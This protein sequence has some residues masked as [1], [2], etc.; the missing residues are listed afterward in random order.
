VDCLDKGCTER[1]IDR[2]EAGVF[3][4]PIERAAEFSREVK[5]IVAD[6]AFFYGGGK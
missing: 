5:E 4:H 6:V 3:P 1:G 2:A